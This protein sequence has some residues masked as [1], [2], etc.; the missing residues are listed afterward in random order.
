MDPLVRRVVATWNFRVAMSG[1]RPDIPVWVFERYQTKTAFQ[2]NPEVDLALFQEGKDSIN[3]LLPN[4]ISI[5]RKTFGDHW[6]MNASQRK[7]DI[8][9]FFAPAIPQKLDAVAMH[10][11]CHGGKLTLDMS[12]LP[13]D[14]SGKVTQAKVIEIQ[15]VIEDADVVGMHMMRM[16][17]KLLSKV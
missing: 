9:Y 15:E 12:Y 11:G 13:F 4:L 16:V 5:L 1:P 2:S 10:L 7:N 8:F 6:S 3:G 14:F 17:R